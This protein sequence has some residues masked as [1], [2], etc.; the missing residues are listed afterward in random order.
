MERKK[1]YTRSRKQE[2]FVVTPYVLEVLSLLA[3][4]KYLRANTIQALLPHRSED[5]LRRTLR[6][7]FDAALVEKPR[8]QFRGY[9]SIYCPDI[10]MLDRD[11]EQALLDRGVNPLA[12]TRLYRE[13]T[14]GPIKNFAHAM[15][16]TDAMASVEV[17]ARDRLIPWTEV[18][19]RTT[20]P[21]PLKLECTIRHRFGERTETLDTAIIPDGFFGVRYEDGKVAFLALEAEHFNPIEPTTLRRSSFLKK[22]L[23]YRNIIERQEYKKQLNVPNM[24]VLVVAPTA[25]RIQHMIE[26]V[27]RLVGQSNLFLFAVIPVQER[28]FKVKDPETNLFERPLLRAG[29]PPITLA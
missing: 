27:E 11:G 14:D 26:L 3:R 12:V 8:E 5:G 10:Y 13:A 19:A 2:A 23:A 20:H 9:N 17:G 22:V 21:N 1:R 16:I 25:Q 18:V 15:M 4:Y 7:M 28:D 29:L 24:R 6:R